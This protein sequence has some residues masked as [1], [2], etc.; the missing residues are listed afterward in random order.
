[1][2]AE[3]REE[4]FSGG[5]RTVGVSGRAWAG[6]GKFRDRGGVVARGRREICYRLG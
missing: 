3:G 2:E 1:M 4:L 6:G 5:G